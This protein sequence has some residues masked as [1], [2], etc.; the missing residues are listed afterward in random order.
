[1]DHAVVAVTS[2]EQAAAPFQKLG[3]RVSDPIRHEGIGSESRMIF[4]GERP[5]QSFYIELFGIIDEA[6]ARATG[7]GPYLDAV[8]R[9]G[10]LTRLMLKTSG[11]PSVAERLRA[12]GLASNVEEISFGGRKSSDLVTLTGVPD[13]AIEAGLF[14]PVMNDAD[15]F[16]RRKAN[17]SFQHD[18]PL[19]RVDHLA[20]M[21][22]D[23]EAATKF[24]GEALGVPVHG[25]IRGPGIIIRQ[26]K[27]G[28]SILELLAPDGPESRLPGR[29][30]GLMSMVA[31]EVPKLDEA[32]ALARDRG[33]SPSE[34][35]GG[36]LPGTRTSTI[37]GG[38]LAGLGLQ[39][40]EYV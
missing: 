35:A 39:M 20:A 40:L 18:F 26:L 37:P 21:A 31:F 14:E 2:T 16:E 34:P 38:E 9:G 5:E 25:E 17:G 27:M 24:W 12:R 28:D 15:V 3:L 30:P 7:R 1:M 8:A 13:L 33:F 23:I 29:P 32:V 22:P 6:K 19:K 11:L 4:A 36:I 10:G